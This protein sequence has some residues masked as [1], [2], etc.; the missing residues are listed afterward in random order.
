MDEQDE[1]REWWP[2]WPLLVM[3]AIF[4]SPIL[5]HGHQTHWRFDAYGMDGAVPLLLGVF[6]I[7]P[8]RGIGIVG[9][10]LGLTASFASHAISKRRRRAAMHANQERVQNGDV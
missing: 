8:I 4:V 2:V 5:V 6:L 1:E 10:S 9:Y 7:W 3:I